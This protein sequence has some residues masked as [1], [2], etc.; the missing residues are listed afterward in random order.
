M[1]LYTDKN[2]SLKAERAYKVI[3]SYGDYGIATIDGVQTKFYF[4]CRNNAGNYYFEIGNK[5]YKMSMTEGAER[6]FN[7]YDFLFL[8]HSNLYTKSKMEE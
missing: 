6:G 7:L 1:L 8:S 4:S 5:W 3:Q 2:I